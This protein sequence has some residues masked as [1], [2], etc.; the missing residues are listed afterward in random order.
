MYRL[1]I[2]LFIAFLVRLLFIGN[3][4][5][6]ADVAFWKSWSLAAADHGIVWT[7]HN[8]NIN[9]PPGFIYILW[10]MGKVYSLFANPHDFNSYWNTNNF[11]FL[12][13]SKMPAIIADLVIGGLIYWFFSQPAGGASGSS[14]GGMFFEHA[15]LS[16]LGGAQKNKPTSANNNRQ[17]RLLKIATPLLLSSL[18]LFNPVTILDSAVWGQVESFGILFTLLAVILIY[19]KK[20]TSA[21]ILFTIG[22]FMKLQNIIYIPLFYLFI[23]RFFDFKAL[24]KSISA[25]IIV[26]IIIIF[27]FLRVHDMDRVIFLMTLNNDYFPWLSLHAHNPWWIIAGGNMLSPDKIL[28][29]GIINAKTLGLILFSSI[30]L[31]LTILIIKKPTIRNFIASLAVAI[32]AFFLL[33]TQSHERYSYPVLIWL[34]MLIPFLHSTKWRNFAYILFGL[35]TIA[36]FYNMHEGLIANYPNGFGFLVPITT[37][38]T[39][40]LNAI[41]MVIL[42]FSLLPFVATEISLIYLSLPPAFIFLSIIFLNF[43]YILNGRVYLTAL[44][45]ISVRQDFGTV[46]Y[47]RSVN[48]YLGPKNWNVLSSNYFFYT[49]GIGTHANSE[50]VFDLNKKFSRFSS[51]FG[52]D[53]EAN[54]KASVIFKIVGDNRELYASPKLGRF[55]F[56]HHADTDIKGVKYLTLIV[57]D[58]GDGINNDHADWLN[59]VLYK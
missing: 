43:S 12:L 19:Y 53:S 56:P 39:N 40:N 16:D 17:N 59:P 54:D 25:S 22:T 24:V 41:F 14:R 38:L 3:P 28:T 55:D 37:P 32:F 58:A 42:F 51:D 35:F 2:L 49:K 5:F 47:N 46:Q 6:V 10:I 31:F 52:I 57:N 48:S 7:A 30:Y 44:K 8:T 18:F 21:S 34:I 29:I 27:P 26:F 1:L 15:H 36:I 11:L 20:P 13:I 4:G 50:L 45:P 23:F 33:T 9:Y